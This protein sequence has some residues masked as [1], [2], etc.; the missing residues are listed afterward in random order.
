MS[1]ED[2]Q[3]RYDELV[4]RCY[5]CVLDPAMWPTLLEQLALATDFQLGTLLLWDGPGD[6][7]Q[8]TAFNHRQEFH[9]PN[10][11]GDLFCVKL[12]EQSGAG[13]YLSL[14]TAAD[15]PVPASPQTRLLLRLTPHLLLAARLASRL[16][17][18]AVELARR[19]LLLE[20][21]ATP[22]WL[23]DDDG[24]VLYSNGAAARLMALNHFA[25]QQ[26]GG[27]LQSRRG[28]S[29][30]QAMLRRA[31]GKDGARRS[32]WLSLA[33][34]QQQGLLVS[35]LRADAPGNGLLQ[36]PLVLLAL[37]ERRAQPQLLAELFQF[38]PAEQR[39]AELLCEGLPPKEC[40]ERLDTSINTVR[41]QLRALFRK[42]GTE[43]QA[44]L[45]RLLT[46]LQQH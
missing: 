36:K 28:D 21:H 4:A 18:M 17:G 20:Q 37:L 14:L 6:D 15:A 26:R 41:T 42:T 24:H 23:L 29:R 3:R 9:L 22:L 5:E 10:G 32:G 46:R 40:A 30:L 19:D 7:P 16:D 25:L 44:E 13:I 11:L 38:T 39:L 27:R 43:R 8:A 33:G 2:E 31:G 34:S 12:L 1:D 35:P 45:V